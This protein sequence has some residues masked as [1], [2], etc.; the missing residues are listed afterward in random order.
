MEPVDMYVGVCESFPKIFTKLSHRVMAT[1]CV[2]EGTGQ[3]KV[4]NCLLRCIEVQASLVL[5]YSPSIVCLG[6]LGMLCS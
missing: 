4:V 5:I 1:P 6:S 2:G 3:N